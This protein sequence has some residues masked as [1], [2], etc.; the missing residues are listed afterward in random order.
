[1]NIGTSGNLSLNQG[2]IITGATLKVVSNNT[3]T[4][5]VSQGNSTSFV[6]GFLRRYIQSTGAY[7]FPVGN[8]TKGYQLANV[9]FTSA[10]TIT[11]L[12]ADFQ[13][14]ATIPVSPT[15]TECGATYS[16]NVLDNG[17][18]NIE[19]NTANN[20]TGAYTMT[21]YNQGYTNA[22]SGWTIMSKHNNEANWGLD[23][24]DLS[25]GTCVASPVTAVVRQNMKG[26]SKFGTAQAPTPLPIELLSF[27]GKSTK[28]Y[29]L[30]EWTTATE[31]NNDYFTLERLQSNETFEPIGTLNAAGNSNHALSYYYKDYTAQPKLNYYRLKQTDTNG[32][33]AYSNTVVIDNTKQ[34][35]DNVFLMHL[36]PN[37]AKEALTVTISGD[38]SSQLRVEL[39]DLL[40]K[41]ILSS[42]PPV[43][44]KAAEIIFDIRS[45]EP[46]MYFI[47]AVNDNAVLDIQK[48][49]KQ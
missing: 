1:M 47:R 44:S 29:N 17:F 3:S 18:W 45:I 12:T 4:T 41:V 13:T 10:T 7:D 20:N 31:I 11:Y 5:S 23:N 39:V 21:L 40:G 9:D 19:A 22:A 49:I 37:P 25:M 43:N 34:A 35:E 28:G 33:F 14:Y 38:A 15:G 30:L 24:G 2:K 36:Y 48:F 6:Q 8:A 42:A 16:G 26:F 32:E 27:T 46:A